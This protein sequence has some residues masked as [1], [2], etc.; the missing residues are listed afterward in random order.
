LRTF[1]LIL[2][3]VAAASTHAPAQRLRGGA[4]WPG[5]GQYSRHFTDVFSSVNNPAAL[6]LATRF[7]VGLYAERRFMLKELTY[8]TLAA[9]LPAPKAAW[10]MQLH[11]VASG[12]YR[13]TE[14]GI[15]CA[16]KLG[17]MNLGIS[18]HYQSVSIAGYSKSSALIAG[19][20]SSWRVTK[21]VQTGLSVYFPAGGKPAGVDKI[22]YA[23]RIGMGYEVSA[24]VLLAFEV[25]QEESRPADTRLGLRY[26]PAPACTIISGIHTATTQPYAGFG[27]TWYNCHLQV[28]VK[29][30]AMLGLTSALGFSYSRPD[31][32][33][34]HETK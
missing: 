20:G 3:A 22:G 16:K 26:R 25:L 9:A 19:I 13:Q 30:H 32:N 28:V 29:Y 15:A 21:D 4:D 6:A 31:K 23:Y 27:F 11:H 2:L 1:N 8:Y 12:S 10:G 18:F 17:A 34:L 14:A 33:D 5:L 7:T 24:Q